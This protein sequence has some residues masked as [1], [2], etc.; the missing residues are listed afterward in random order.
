MPDVLGNAS[1]LTALQMSYAERL[2]L[3]RQHDPFAEPRAWETLVA[4]GIAGVVT[5]VSIY[6]L[7]VV[8]TRLQT[9]S[10]E[11]EGQSVARRAEG[12]TER[13]QSMLRRRSG[14]RMACQVSI[15]VVGI[16]SVR[17]F[18]VNAVQWY[19][20]EQIMAFLRAATLT[21]ASSR[22]CILVR[23]PRFASPDSRPYSYTRVLANRCNAAALE[24]AD[25]EPFLCCL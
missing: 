9:Q 4:G 6:P 3:S 16:C 24:F 25:F 12:S 11:A 7:D 5:W 20:Y 17:A 15:E 8:K 13:D 10:V 1:M 21:I 19:A 14:G 2:L 18:V 23:I 22:T